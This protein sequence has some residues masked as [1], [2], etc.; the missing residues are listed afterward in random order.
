MKYITSIFIIAAVAFGVWKVAS[1]KAPEA[2]PQV[3]VTEEAATSNVTAVATTSSA[4]VKSAA[5]SF[6][7]YG[8]GKEHTGTFK[9]IAFGLSTDAEG[10]IASGSVV[11]D[12]SSVNTGIEGLDK[13]LV[14][15]DF[16]DATAYP[17]IT[18]TLSN[19]AWATTGS[20]TASGTLDF[21]GVKK[22]ISFP[23]SYDEKAKTYSADLRIKASDFKLKYTAIK[24]EVRVTFSVAL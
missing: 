5:F 8:P 21:H 9:N 24:D 6:T 18:F 2:I 22:S 19:I 1:T 23:I 13:H 12:A 3:T 7:G 16:F 17:S 14:G 11:F 4:V 20:S 10:R 15:A